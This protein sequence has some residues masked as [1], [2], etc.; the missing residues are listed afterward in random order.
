MVLII[1]SGAQLDVFVHHLLFMAIVFHFSWTSCVTDFAYFLKI[2]TCLFWCVFLCDHTFSLYDKYS[3][4]EENYGRDFNEILNEWKWLKVTE[5]A[6]GGQKASVSKITDTFSRTTWGARPADLVFFFPTA[7]VTCMHSSA[8]VL[9]WSAIVG[10]YFP[11]RGQAYGSLGDDLRLFPINF[12]T[13]LSLSSHFHSART[14]GL[15]IHRSLEDIL[16]QY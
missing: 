4:Y 7:L 2:K 3:A 12:Q 11:A 16:T 13:A 5:A 15:S 6:V 8:A 10:S 14:I 9:I 1:T